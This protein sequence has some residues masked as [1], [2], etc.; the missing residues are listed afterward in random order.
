MPMC[1]VRWMIVASI[2]SAGFAEAE[3][4]IESHVPP[5]TI[6]D[7][8]NGVGMPSVPSA[9]NT[10]LIEPSRPSS[11]PPGDNERHNTTPFGSISPPHEL[12]PAPLLP[13]NPNRPLMPY[14]A[15]PTPH[16]GGRFGR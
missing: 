1:V 8:G 16:T 6:M 11:L 7:L 13:F 15:P 9:A 12:T 4:G 3:I 2:L 10:P 5:G 14:S